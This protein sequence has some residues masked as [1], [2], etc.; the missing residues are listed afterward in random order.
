MRSDLHFSLHHDDFLKLETEEQTA[1]K[2]LF[3]SVP[4]RDDEGMKQGSSK[5]TAGEGMHVN[6]RGCESGST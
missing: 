5:D 2:R 4:T 6:Y 3:Q 1:C